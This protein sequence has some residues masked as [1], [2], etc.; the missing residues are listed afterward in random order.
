MRRTSAP[1][2]NN[3]EGG[4]LHMSIINDDNFT[5]VRVSRKSMGT[6]HKLPTSPGVRQWG[7]YPDGLPEDSTST[8][9]PRSEAGKSPKSIT[10]PQNHTT[11]VPLVPA[12]RD[13]WNRCASSRSLTQQRRGVPPCGSQTKGSKNGKPTPQMT[14]PRK[15]T[16]PYHCGQGSLMGLPRLADRPN[17]LPSAPPVELSSHLSQKKRWGVAH[18]P[19]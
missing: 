18:I 15:S 1:V 17:G 2:C 13:P 16:R 11:P 7:P 9:A 8:S 6:S 10:K 5:S 3:L 4:D 19:Q 12:R 14:N